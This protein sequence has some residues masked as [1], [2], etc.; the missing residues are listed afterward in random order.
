MSFVKHIF[1]LLN[2]VKNKGTRV[3]TLALGFILECGNDITF[4]PFGW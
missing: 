4:G 1:I 2:H 3:G